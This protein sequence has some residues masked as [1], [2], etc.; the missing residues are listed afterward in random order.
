MGMFDSVAFICPG[1]GKEFL[2]Q[3]KAGECLLQYF[4]AEACPPEIA[5]GFV[6][7]IVTCY[8]CHNDWLVQGELPRDIKL[9]LTAPEPE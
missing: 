3:T 5:R 8:H 9:T 7:C 1:C 2:E 6:N 4:P